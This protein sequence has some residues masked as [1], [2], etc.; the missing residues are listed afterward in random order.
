M[1]ENCMQCSLEVNGVKPRSVVTVLDLAMSN[2]P[3]CYNE[4]IASACF[5]NMKCFRSGLSRPHISI[6]FTGRACNYY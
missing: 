1:A 5:R 6:C 3:N 4:L 2:D